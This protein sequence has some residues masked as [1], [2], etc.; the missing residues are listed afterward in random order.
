MRTHLQLDPLPARLFVL[1]VELRA[2]CLGCGRDD[3]WRSVFVRLDTPRSVLVCMCGES[4]AQDLGVVTK[5][6][7]PERHVAKPGRHDECSTGACAVTGDLCCGGHVAGEC[8]DC[9]EVR[10]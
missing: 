8:G 1:T 5:P 10:T 9:D 4:G 2:R 3:N 6:R 7:R